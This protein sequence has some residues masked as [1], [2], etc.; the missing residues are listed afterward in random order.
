MRIL[1]VED[2]ELVAD[3]VVQGL[4]ASQFSVDHVTSAELARAAFKV[5]VFDAA[6]IDIGLPGEDGIMLLTHLRREQNHVPIL[7]LTA[8][9][10]VD[11]KVKALE[12]GADDF[13]AKPFSQEELLARCRA[14]I[15]RATLRSVGAIQ[16]GNMEIDL[17]FHEL[18]IEGLLVELT[19]REWEVFEYLVRHVGRVVPKERLMQSIANLDEEL[20]MNALEVYISRLRSKLSESVTIRTIRGLGYRLEAEI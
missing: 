11:D 19:S 18:R 17:N 14:L 20:T 6:V 10:S 8:R 2:D 1:V 7:I 4:R 5:A 15:R 12:S 3:A 16:F 13:L 9:Q